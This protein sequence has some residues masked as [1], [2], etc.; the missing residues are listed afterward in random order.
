MEWLLYRLNTGS[1]LQESVST[2]PRLVAMEFARPLAALESAV[3]LVEFL[4]LA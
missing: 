1:V 4:G 2:E 3:E